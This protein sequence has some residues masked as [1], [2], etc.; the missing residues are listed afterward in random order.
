[1]VDCNHIRG[2]IKH[3]KL[4]YKSVDTSTIKG[5]KYAEWLKAHGWH[6]I[7]IGFNTLTF[8]KG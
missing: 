8:E 5:L 1:M 6:I 3:M 7:A 4:N 2:R